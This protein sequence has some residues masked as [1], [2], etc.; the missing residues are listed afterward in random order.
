MKNNLEVLFDTILQVF[1]L[2]KGT[3]NY[4]PIIIPNDFDRRIIDSKLENY[5]SSQTNLQSETPIS[6]TYKSDVTFDLSC[7]Q[8]YKSIT[9][10]YYRVSEIIP[11]NVA[12]NE[13]STYICHLDVEQQFT[14]QFTQQLE[15]YDI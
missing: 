7:I 11:T 3:E 13:I 9:F 1:E 8:C 2:S 6:V 10:R 12:T 14:Q 4:I 5:V 15:S